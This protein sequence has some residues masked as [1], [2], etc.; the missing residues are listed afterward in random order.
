[1]KW[2][3]KFDQTLEK[4]IMFTDE[5]DDGWDVVHVSELSGFVGRAGW[6]MGH[7]WRFWDTWRVVA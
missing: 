5:D 1:L 7:H 3:K 4:W 2:R 6:D